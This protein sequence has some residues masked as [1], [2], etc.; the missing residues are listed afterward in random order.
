MNKPMYIEPPNY[1]DYEL[2][3]LGCEYARGW[4]DAMDAIFPQEAEKRKK[5]KRKKELRGEK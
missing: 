3:K 2:W 4:N 5:E 1:R